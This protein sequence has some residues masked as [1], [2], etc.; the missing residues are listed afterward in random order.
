VDRILAMEVTTRNIVVVTVEGE[1]ESFE[2]EIVDE[3][4]ITPDSG[5]NNMR[6][7]MDGKAEKTH[8]AL[9]SL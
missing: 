2:A 9:S 5:K 7:Y 3:R 8:P 6:N 4:V 1:P